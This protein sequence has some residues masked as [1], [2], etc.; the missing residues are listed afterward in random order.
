MIPVNEERLITLPDEY[1]CDNNHLGDILRA[2]T[3]YYPKLSQCT[4]K[5]RVSDISYT[6]LYMYIVGTIRL[7]TFGCLGFMGSIYLYTQPLGIIWG[8]IRQ[9]HT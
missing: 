9:A 3:L 6:L 8:V 1:T 4:L 7:S 5:Y 2:L